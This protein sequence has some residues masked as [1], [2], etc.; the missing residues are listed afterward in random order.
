MKPISSLKFTI[1]EHEWEFEQ[2]HRLNYKTFVEEIPQHKPNKDNRLIDKF[3]GENTYVICKDGDRVVGMV[4]IKSGRPFSLDAKLDDLDSFLPAKRKTVELRLLSVEP[5]YRHGRILRELLLFTA[6]HC[7][8][9]G[10]NLA[11]ISATTRQTKL[12]KHM[13]FVP[14]GPLVGNSDA[15]F[16]PMYLTL[17]NFMELGNT[18][19][20]PSIKKDNNM[21]LKFLP[22]PVDINPAVQDAFALAPI[23]HR[24]GGFVKDFEQI[25]HRLCSLFNAPNVAICIGSGTLAN[26]IIAGQIKLTNRPGLVISNGEFGQRLIDHAVRWQLDF[27]T[28]EVEWGDIFT[29][30]QIENA[31]DTIENPGWL[32]AV[33]CE[34]STGILNDLDQLKDICSR[35]NLELHADCISSIGTMPVDLSGVQLASSVSGKGLGAYPGLAMVFYRDTPLPA[36]NSL[37]RYIDLSLYDDSQGIP[38]THSTNLVYALRTAIDLFEKNTERFT[39]INECSEWMRSELREM[40]FHIVAP[41]EFSSPAVITIEL[42]DE[43]DSG[44]FGG[45]MDEQGFL[46]SYR[47][48]YLLKR[49]WIQICFMGEFSKEK[50]SELVAALKTVKPNIKPVQSA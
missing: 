31:L 36:G 45:N 8:N 39:F 19:C 33:H 38:F 28:L 6:N 40:G 35:R 17:E 26:D 2:I 5:E 24:S 25:R 14:F 44:E 12:Y 41:D 13:G 49:N 32:W 22:G 29:P 9:Q 50:L 3:H 11:I 46:L 4:A 47:S 15:L 34:T 30:E 27:K 42:P 20:P 37:P 43:I 21:P 1:A 18:I 48:Q 10:F 16:Q 7:Y 23:S